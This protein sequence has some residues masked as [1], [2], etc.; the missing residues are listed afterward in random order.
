MV[1]RIAGR[2]AHGRTADGSSLSRAAAEGRL[3]AAGRRRSRHRRHRRRRR[4]S[5]HRAGRAWR[6][7]TGRRPGRRRSRRHA[8]LTGGL[9]DLGGG[10]PQGGADLVDLDLVDGALLA[11]LGLVRPLPEPALDDD[12]HATLEALGDVLRRL[13]PDVA[14]QEQRLAVLPLVGLLVHEPRSGRDAEPGHRLPR[15]GEAQLRVVDEIADDGDRGVACCHGCVP[16][17]TASLGY[18]SEYGCRPTKDG[19]LVHVRAQDLGAQDA[20]VEVE[21]AVE[22][23]HRGGLE[24]FRSMTA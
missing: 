4:R 7:P 15:G 5:R 13:P 16:S 22:L 18:G 19:C 3:V 24:Q 11:F 21:L 10:V 1:A 17:C 9:V 8:A 20:L 23:L 2:D 12:P 6:T 14:G